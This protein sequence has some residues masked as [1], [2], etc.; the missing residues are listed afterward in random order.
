MSYL[1]IGLVLFLG[2]HSVRMVAGDWR[3]ARVAALGAVAWKGISALIS[4]AGIALIVWGYDLARGAPVDLWQPAPW[5]RH[6]AGILTLLAFLLLV[7][8]F[9]PGSWIRSLAGGHPMVI[10]VMIW[11]TGHLFANGRLTDLLLFGGFLAWSVFA[12]RSLRRRDRASGTT[13]QRGSPVNDIVTLLVGL[14][15]WYLF[16]LHLHRILFGV[17]PFG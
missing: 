7:S 3:E 4:L 14:T 1:I 13:A 9:V 5:A 8:A 16:A 6:L 15:L 10:A 12:W 2:I 17:P 11:S